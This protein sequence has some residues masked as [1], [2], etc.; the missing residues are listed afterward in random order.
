MVYYAFVY[1]YLQITR[2]YRILYVDMKIKQT[3]LI[4][5]ILVGLG[6][7]MIGQTVIAGKCAG[8]STSI[9]DCTSQDGLIKKE[10]CADRISTGDNID[11]PEYPKEGSDPSTAYDPVQSAAD[12]LHAYKHNYGVCRDGSMPVTVYDPTTIADI[13][14]TG[15]WYLLV[16]AI[17]IL[18]AGIGVVAVGGLV[19]GSILYA[20]AGGGPEQV[21][22]AKT[23]ITDIVIGLV[24]YAFMY[25]FLNFIIPGGLFS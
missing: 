15:I 17:N 25:A 21:K 4:F 13:K 7:I 14:K 20:S 19:Y 3:I 23:I 2:F 6:S 1:R 24:A 9:I 12:Y 10:D 8:V 16:I 22:K 5:T 18:T 11:K